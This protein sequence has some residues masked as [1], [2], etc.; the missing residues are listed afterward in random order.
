M[1]CQMLLCVLSLDQRTSSMQTLWVT[2]WL[3]PFYHLRN[4]VSDVSNLSKHALLLEAKA[5]IQT[6]CLVIISI[7]IFIILTINWFGKWTLVLSH[8]VVSDSVTSWTVAHQA[9]LSMAILQAK[10]LEWVFMPSSRWSSQ[11]RDWTEVS[12][13]AGKFLTI[14]ATREAQEYWSG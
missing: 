8:S 7:C 5:M 10:I 14:W 2:V 12:R 4:D 3:S 13:I 1:T 11:P 9:P 6:C